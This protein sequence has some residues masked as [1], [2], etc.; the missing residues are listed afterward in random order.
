MPRLLYLDGWVFLSIMAEV[1]LYFV[2][3]SCYLDILW[4]GMYLTIVD[5]AH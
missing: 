1:T 4:S 5:L 2:L 3:Q